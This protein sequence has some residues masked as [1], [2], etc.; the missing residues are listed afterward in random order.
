MESFRYFSRL[1]FIIL[2]INTLVACGG[3]SSSN[4]AQQP[5][6]KPMVVEVTGNKEVAELTSHT[7][8]SS[9][10]NSSGAVTYQWHYESELALDVSDLTQSSLTVT[11]QDIEADGDAVFTLTVTD[12][13]D[14]TV[15]ASHTIVFKAGESVTVSV[16]GPE[17]ITDA[18]TVT[19][20][21]Q[22]DGLEVVSYQWQ[23]DSELELNLSGQE[24]AVLTVATPTLS[25]P[26]V[27]TFTLS[28][29]DVHGRTY[30]F[31]HVVT[32]AANSTGP[33]DSEPNKAPIVSIEGAD[34]ARVQDTVILSANASDPDGK[35]SQY[36]WSSD[37]SLP[38]QLSNVHTP[39]LSF[40]VPQI[41]EPQTVTFTL[42]VSDDEALS[43]QAT[44][45]VELLPFPNRSPEVTL[46][47]PLEVMENHSVTITAQAND[48]DG[49]ISHY[50]WGYEGDVSLSIGDNTGAELVL[51]HM[52]VRQDTELNIFVIVTDDDGA[53]SRTET[54]ITVRALPEV[55]INVGPQALIEQQPVTFSA[56]LYD[57]HNRVA[58]YTWTHNGKDLLSAEGDLSEQMTLQ[59]TDI[60]E[61]LPVTVSLMV[62]DTLG[63]QVQAQTE[64][65]IQ[66]LKHML[67]ISGE[68]FAKELPVSNTQVTAQVDD[69]AQ[70]VAVDEAGRYVL[71]LEL[72]ESQANAMIVLTAHQENNPMRAAASVLGEVKHL[73]AL[74]GDDKVLTEEELFAVN[75]NAATTAEFALLQSDLGLPIT[76]QQLREARASLDPTEKRALTGLFYDFSRVSERNLNLPNGYPDLVAL[77]KNLRATKR[78]L[79]QYQREYGEAADRVR[80]Q[81][82]QNPNLFEPATAVP[83]G[84]YLL[85]ELSYFNGFAASLTLNEDGS[86]VLNATESV[87]F[88]WSQ[89]ES[90]ILLTLSRSLGIYRNGVA[91]QPDYFAEQL[92]LSLSKD[93]DGN[94]AASVSIPGSQSAPWYTRMV[95]L[96]DLSA[97]SASDFFGQWSMSF[98]HSASQERH[99]DINLFSD[100]SARVESG[101]T[102]DFTHWQ[103]QGAQLELTL[104]NAPYRMYILREFPLGYQ[105][106]IEYDGEQGKV[107]VP[108]VMVRHQKT[109]F[110][111]LNYTRTWNLLFRQGES[112]VFSIDEDNH[113]HYLWRRNVWGDKQ[114]G[115]L[116]QQRFEFA[117]IDTLWC[118][119][120]LLQCEA[121]LTAAYRLLSVHG[122]LIAVEYATASNPLS[123]GVSKRQLYVFELSDD[124][125]STP[126][127]TDGIFKAS[128]SGAFAGTASL[129]GLTE[130]GVVHLQG[131]QHCEPFSPQPYCAEAIYIG[132]QKYW[133]S[134]AGEDIKLVTIDRST[135]RYLT[136]TDADQQGITLCL[137]EDVGLQSCNETNSLYYQFLAPNL[138]IEYVVSGEG[139]LQPSV[140]TVSY[141]QS[142]ETLI[143]PERG[144]ELD[145]ISGCQGVLKESDNGTLLYS[146][147]E[148]QQS[149]TINASFKRTAPHVGRNVVLVNNGDVPHSWYMDI[150]RNGTGTLTTRTHV[151]DFKITQQSESVYVA[152]LNGGRTVSVRDGQGKTHI[153]TGFAFEYQPDGAYLSWHHDTVFKRTVFTT[154]IQFAKDLEAL[155]IDPQ[156]LAGQWALTFGEYAES[157]QT[158]TQQ[159]LLFNL[160]ADHTGELRAGEQTPWAQQHELNWSLTEQNRLRLSARSGTLIA[161]F[162]LIRQSKWGYQFVIEEV[163][164]TSSGYHNDW[165]QHGA[166]LLIKREAQ[167]LQLAQLA[168]KWRYQSAN[169][170]D[171]FELYTDGTYRTSKFNGAERASVSGS[172]LSVSAAY[173]TELEMFDPIC[174]IDDPQCVLGYHKTYTV[175]SK[176]DDTLFVLINESLSNSEAVIRQFELDNNP[177]LTQFEAQ[178]FRAELEL[179]V[180]IDTP[181][182]NYLYEVTAQQTRY[183]RFFERQHEQGI[184]QYLFIEGEGATEVAIEQGKLLFGDAQQYQ[185]EIIESTSE[186]VLVCR[187]ARG[188]Y[189]Q[190]AD[191]HFLR[192]EVPAYEVTLDVGPGGEVVTDISGSYILYG[193]RIGVEISYQ[194]DQVLSS[195]SG[196]DLSFDYENERVLHFYGPGIASACHISARFEPWLGS[197]S[198]RLEMTDPFLGACVDQ[199]NEAPDR[200]IEFRTHLS[201]DGQDNLTL[202]DISGLAQ[203]SQL[204]SLQLRSAAQ[205]SPSALAEL[206]TLTQIT[207]LSLSDIAITELDL[208]SM[209]GLEKLSLALPELTALTLPQRSALT[210]L[211]ITQG[212]PAGLALSGQT[213]LTRLDLSGSAISRLDLSGLQN[214]TSLQASNS[215]LEE[216]TFVDATLP[217]GKLW[218]DNTPLSQLELSRFPQLTHAKLDHTQLSALDI[219]ENREIYH[220]S[221]QHTPLEYFVSAR[222][223]PLKKLILSSTQLTSIALTTMPAL[224]WLEIDN[225][226]L[227]TL[228][229]NGSHVEHLSAKGNQLTSLTVPDD[230]KLRRLWLDDN[231]IASV[232][233]PEDNPWLYNLSLSGNQLSTFETLGP[234]NLNSLDLSHNPLTQFGVRL[235]S[236]LHTLNLSYTQLEEV[237]IATMNELRTLVINHT[238]ISQL[239]LEARLKHLDISN[240]KVTKLHLP[241][242]MEN[243]EIYF[244]G[245]TLSSLTAT[246]SQRNIR[247]FLEGSEL[248][249]QAREFLIINQ[250]QIRGFL[251]R[252]LSVPAECTILTH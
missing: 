248:S 33:S 94:L 97:Y 85:S 123:A 205:I 247:L 230:A 73:I 31:A 65:T 231:Q 214:L 121:K 4:E 89:V 170:S 86:G 179:E 151:V 21:G 251:C 84:R 182:S 112:E 2:T 32:F 8:T 68:V 213:S 24:S 163:K 190:V 165:F 131:G 237:D 10:D 14:R 229:L 245:N 134:M 36:Q 154:Q 34:Q 172:T 192:Y 107:M 95:A 181:S 130:Q 78:Q 140:N 188:N 16:V 83:E 224:D 54:N 141:K 61:D 69:V 200:H 137:R 74:G 88:N 174:S 119:V 39:E 194:Q 158:H 18:D 175:L 232:K 22:A 60:Q 102:T 208:S 243:T 72:D 57:P 136:L 129:Y 66:A 252:D 160:N 128:S 40:T 26:V 52:D 157:Q 195:L 209:S 35:I 115:K 234:Q 223:V 238:P 210:S 217:V 132:E 169:Q 139:A 226:R 218:L 239:A 180:G 244:A 47:S 219:T 79:R 49:E 46:V 44:H 168:G 11:S 125:L 81:V 48:P 98:A 106:L 147:T 5:T 75:I 101:A 242:D 3:S 12:E 50:E 43:A 28:V 155:A 58:S 56:Q 63:N 38:L 53:Q 122:D 177:G 93:P 96:D 13:L 62:K 135:T 246:G 55:S 111:E 149:C 90:G 191:Q 9:V 240:T 27:V 116:V 6:L 42:V 193:R 153:V 146:V 222:N 187:Y 228:D 118:D 148:P 17:K 241:D 150:H 91:A 120:S 145:E 15:Q 109:S 215:Q 117:G 202:T 249:D 185:L 103:L 152:R 201:C 167:P 142:F 108:G 144:F 138:D 113:Y 20:E 250:G 206:N 59:S 161:E 183:W 30:Q 7:L 189:C 197:Q 114:D 41:N 80:H 176:Q 25:S 198:A 51:S 104:D 204:T 173:N 203:F 29:K 220:L 99:Y 64:L 19:F 159:H 105:L 110:D 67:T 133:A 1:F 178:F 143:L 126:R 216:I 77:A 124:V 70:T 233:L 207:E 37:S 162:K 100:G 235:N 211:S 76:Q 186:G 156:V 23:H 221:A 82:A 196:C 127:L 199:Y 71:T 171:G 184:K 92:H 87:P 225:A 164:K 45:L 227:T 236:R 166:G 212:G